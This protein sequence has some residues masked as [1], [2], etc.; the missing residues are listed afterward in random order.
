MAD[1]VRTVRTNSQSQYLP[2]TFILRVYTLLDSVEERFLSQTTAGEIINIKF[3]KV[4]YI[5]PLFFLPPSLA[6]ELEVGF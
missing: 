4:A 1:K 5:L 3:T 6:A 2:F